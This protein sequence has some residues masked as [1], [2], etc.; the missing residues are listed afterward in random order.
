[1]WLP[2]IRQL[3]RRGSRPA[4]SGQRRRQRLLVLEALEDRLVPSTFTVTST[5]D[6][7]TSGTLRWAITQANAD[8]ATSSLINFNIASSG[9]QTIQ[10]GSSS[11]Y[12][13]QPLPAITHSVTING[14][15]EGGYNGSPLIVVDGTQA[16]SGST[17]LF[18]SAVNSSVKGLCIGDFSG[19]Y[20]VVLSGGSATGDEITADYIG[21]NAAGIAALPNAIGVIISSGA[22]GNT[23]GGTAAG[24]GNTISG[25]SSVGVYVAGSGT[26]SN[27]VQGNLIGTNAAGTAALPNN[28]GV[29]IE[30][31]ANS[32]TI[33]G[34]AAGAGNTISGNTNSGV[35]ISHNLTGTLVEGN[36][37][38]TNPAGT[39]ALPN[40]IGVNISNGPSNNTIGGTAAGAGNII[41]GNT[42]YGVW[43]T[44]GGVG[45]HTT[46]TNLVQG[47]LIGTN[48]AGTAAVPNSTGVRIDYGANNNN[49]GGTA[50]GA[51]NTISGNGGDGV[52]VYSANGDAILGNSISANG[53]LGIHLDSASNANDN[54]A[55][56]LLSGVAGSAT[57]TT[58]SGSLTSVANTTFRI[59]FFSNIAPNL[60]GYGEGRSYL[61][62]TTVTTN[63]SGSGSFTFTLAIPL[64]AGQT[65]IS[66]TA[67]N[68][69]TN[70]TSPFALDV[71]IPVV[72]AITAPL[73]PVAV[74]TSI[75]VSAPFTDAITTT[76]HMAFWNW[77]DNTTSA[78]TVTETNGSGTVTASHTYAA[79][80]VYTVTLTV[81]N[82]LGGSGQSV[83]LYVV[84]YNPSAGFVTGGGRITSPAGAFAANTSLT[85]NVDFGF[86]AKYKSGATI[87]TGNTDF[88]YPAAN[89]SFQSTSYDWLVITTN[90]GQVQGSGTIN[91]VG[92]F[93]FLVTA[94]DNGGVSLD[95]LR[96]KI[97]DKNNNNAVIYDTQPGAA[98]T[99][100][101]TTSLIGGRIKVHTN[102]QLVAGGPNPSGGNVAP[103]TTVEL[104]PIVQEAI[105]RWAAAG[106]DPARLRALSHVAVGI[107]EFLSPWLG[108]AFPGAIWINRDAA[109]YGWY[110]G[111]AS[112][113]DAGFSA[114]PGSPAYGKVDLLTVVEHELGHELGFED[115]T[116]DG[117][118]GVFLGTG[119]RRLPAAESAAGFPMSQGVNLALTLASLP[120]CGNASTSSAT[121]ALGSTA[122]STTARRDLVFPLAGMSAEGLSLGTRQLLGR[123]REEPIRTAS[124]TP[125]DAVFA[126]MNAQAIFAGSAQRDSE[127]EQLH[128]PLFS[129]PN[130]SE[131]AD[132]IAADSTGPRPGV[133]LLVPAKRV[134]PFPPHV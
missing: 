120:V 87:P 57:G 39:A 70:D 32:N 115:T 25:N 78:G 7:G 134:A 130:A 53:G 94:Q 16:G 79:D 48:A 49:I 14:T 82:N 65:V 35:R 54:Q 132:F 38:G 27:V 17:G 77:G 129:D 75:N 109:G 41:S 110:I 83:F 62:F 122:T 24:A 112:V 61:G 96:I 20:G 40:A 69:T 102:A 63:S 11:N 42:S 80:G 95:L 47:N 50:A 104:Q 126:S 29:V 19:G 30:Y 18:L 103:L 124:V 117:L 98:T 113:A 58:I 114:V 4:A 5:A 131:L 128:V 8:T 21:T 67:T 133:I 51:G 1:M 125:T 84:V 52:F 88:E 33:G 111:A 3:V 22:S 92:N 89:L 15:T 106:I 28:E 10:V 31:G 71:S 116:G 59:E 44:N 99:A 105:A 72:G 101:P 26:M 73:A 93:G 91:G 60:S 45:V 97:W 34:T 127:D 74:N 43:I 13:G 81:T 86:D 36:F 23:I 119:V 90:Q 76:T 6:D 9:V 118:M 55:A 64:P 56:P 107:A 68:Q 123:S 2:S 46:T 37:I 12:S 108:M 66:A 85:G 100:A 121:S